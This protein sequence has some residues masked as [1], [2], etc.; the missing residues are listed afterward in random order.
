MPSLSFA[1]VDVFTKTR[2]GG[3]PLAVVK[4][5]HGQHVSSE[6][7]QLIA[8]EFNLS[9][10]IF[11]HLPQ[12]NSQSEG[13]TVP[14]WT[15][16]IFTTEH[17]I[18]FAGHPTIGCACFVFTALASGLTMARL[19][20]N[21]GPIELE[22]VTGNAVAKAQIPHNFHRHT[23]V[24]FTE[25]HVYA[26]QEKLRIESVK[27][28]AI[29]TLSP[30]KGM[31]F[32]SIRLPDLDALSKVE[33]S[34]SRPQTTLDEGWR[35]GFIGLYFYVITGDEDHQGGERTVKVRTRMIA[36]GLE[37]PATGSAACAL[38]CF[39]ATSRKSRKT[40][41]EVTQAVEMGRRSEI[42]VVVILKEDGESVESVELSGS[43]V[44]VMEGTVEY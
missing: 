33:A 32:I 3:N 39:L 22:Y 35:V 42:G 29:D 10:T 1:T 38:G 4:I 7:M 44:K 31:N 27:L 41:F 40:K 17:E 18:P 16:R 30:V 26:L 19:I 8:T 13:K 20:C 14:E 5:W 6:Q 15:V 24:P 25:S 11:I 43:A 12:S 37:D 2:F 9:E 28:L 36:G 34:G 21:A 23:E